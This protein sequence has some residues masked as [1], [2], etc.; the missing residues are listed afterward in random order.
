MCVL[1]GWYEGT[2]S[3][4]HKGI[5]KPSAIKKAASFVAAISK[6]SP[7]FHYCGKYFQSPTVSLFLPV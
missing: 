5:E 1:Q 2:L 7:A 6:S 3:D 4:S